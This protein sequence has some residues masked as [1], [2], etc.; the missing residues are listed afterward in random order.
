[1]GRVDDRDMLAR[2]L[3]TLSSEER[4]SIAL[5]FG[6]DMTAPEIAKLLG[7]KLTTIEGRIYRALGKLRGELGRDPGSSIES[8]S[9]E[10]R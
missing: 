9:P 2:A 1:M 4:E 10:W 5:R 7:A 6:A 3:A 8:N